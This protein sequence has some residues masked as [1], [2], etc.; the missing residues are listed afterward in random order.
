MKIKLKKTL[1][2]DL[3]RIP[4]ETRIQIEALVFEEAPELKAITEIQNIKKIKGHNHFYR[5]RFG[6]YR[7]GIEERKN[8]IVFYRALHRKDIYRN[9]P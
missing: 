2:K 9:F 5:V 6:Q 4:S 3:K 1:I 7:I 8:E